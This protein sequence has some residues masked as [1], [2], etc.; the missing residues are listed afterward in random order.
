MILVTGGLGFIGLNTAR[1]LLEA[2]ESCVLTRR[3][4][5]RQP[6][7]LRTELGGRAF[8]E[9][10]DV[11]D[12]DALLELGK[13]YPIN[14][15]I[16]LAG[17]SGAGPDL[18]DDLKS[19][20]DGLLA[21]L[22]AARE[23]RVPRVSVASTIGVYVGVTGVPWR[24]DARLPMTAFHPIE[25]MKKTAELLGGL[26]AGPSGIEVV[27]L[28]IGAIWGP[29]GRPDS[30]FMAAPRMVNAAFAGEPVRFTPPRYARDGIDLCYARDCG[31][32]IALV[33]TAPKL[34]H[35]VYNVGTGRMTSNEEVAEAVRAVIPDAD[36]ELAPGHDPAGPAGDQYLDIERLR[37]DTGYR[38]EY[39][40]ERAVRDYVDWLRESAGAQP[41]R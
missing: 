12:P 7:F 35:R 16:H 15:I 10:L 17:S 5:A 8:I 6:E 23:W 22:R 36:I 18:I 38:P 32:A 24:E 3:R 31:R 29:F 2:G 33:Q 14:G 39:G 11:T 25:T 4:T 27:S 9:P 26:V 19:H 30:R 21:V 1:A 20:V 34:N 28:R 41:A 13:R 40:A 37:S